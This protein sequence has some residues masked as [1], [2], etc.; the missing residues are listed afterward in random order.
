MIRKFD[1]FVLLKKDFA[2]D[3]NFSPKNHKNCLL[4]VRYGIELLS[5][6]PFWVCI[7][8]GK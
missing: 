7:I 2:K 4:I 3:S 6:H 1:I 8:I 5:L